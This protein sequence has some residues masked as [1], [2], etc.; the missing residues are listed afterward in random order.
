MAQETKPKIE[1]RI[2]FVAAAFMFMTALFLDLTQILLSITGVFILASDLVTFMA[3]PAFGIWFLLLR[4]NYFGGKKAVAKVTAALVT[5]VVELVPVVDALPCITIGVISVIRSSR[6][7][8][9]EAKPKAK[10]A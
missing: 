8:D 10:P 5:V 4:V 2:G 9:R 7:E 1:Y 3:A 6:A